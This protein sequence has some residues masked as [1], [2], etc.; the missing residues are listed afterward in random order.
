[1]AAPVAH[2]TIGRR[3]T[4]TQVQGLNWACPDCGA[5]V[6]FFHG[7]QTHD[8]WHAEMESRL[9]CPSPRARHAR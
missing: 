9:L 3:Y 5:V 4:E 1:M 8:R 7:R 2:A 6:E